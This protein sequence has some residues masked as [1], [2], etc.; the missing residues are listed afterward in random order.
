MYTR[1]VACKYKVKQYCSHREER[2]LFS[3]F[4]SEIKNIPFSLNIHLLSK[5]YFPFHYLNVCIF[6]CDTFLILNQGHL[7]QYNLV[8]SF[9][10]NFIN[11]QS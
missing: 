7:G 8:D 11:T 6:L 2:F 4:I 3:N 1:G 10:H 9:V 5:I